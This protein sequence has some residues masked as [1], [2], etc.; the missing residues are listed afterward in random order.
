M[1]GTSIVALYRTK[2]VCTLINNSHPFVTSV[3]NLVKNILLRDCVSP[4]IGVLSSLRFQSGRALERV[5]PRAYGRRNRVTRL[6]N[7]IKFK[8]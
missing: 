8:R 5:F 6:G 7:N 4:P 1:P 3:T 2:S